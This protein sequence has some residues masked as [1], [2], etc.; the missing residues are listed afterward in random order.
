MKPLYLMAAAMVLLASSLS[1]AQERSFCIECHQEESSHEAGSVHE[2]AG[3]SCH[4]CHG[5]DPAMEDKEAAKAKGT[6]YLGEVE[7]TLVPEMCGGCHSDVREMNP[8]GLPTDQLDQYRFSHHGRALFERGITDVAACADCHGAHGMRPVQDPRSPVYPKNAPGTCGRCHAD[9]EKMEEHGIET[10][11]V[12]D[13]KRSIH[14]S[15]LFEEGGLSA[16]TCVTCHG[17]HSAVPPGFRKV[18]EVCGKC[19]IKQEDYFNQGPHAKAAEKG[20]LETCVT[21]HSNHKVLPA[22]EKLFRTCTLCHEK[23]EDAFNTAARIYKLM[24][25]TR[26]KYE[27]AKDKVEAAYRTGFAVE[28]QQVLL[29]DARTYLLQ[30]E[31]MQHSLDLDEIEE[32]S[33]RVGGLTERILKS[34]EDKKMQK[35]ARRLALIPLSG[36][37]ALMSLVFWL[38]KRQIERRDTNVS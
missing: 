8:Y 17:N 35:R 28:D 22:S 18:G 14:A 16:P 33:E 34:I 4:R 13:Y 38:K 6:G 2:R 25:N 12:E 21:C 31:P 27:G 32:T 26:E 3:V 7:K 9:E 36:F 20:E 5:G 11:Q 24:G 29:S 37:M 15:M 19:H 10:G 30:L 23:G 1:G